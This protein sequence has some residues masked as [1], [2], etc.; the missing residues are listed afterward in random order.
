[1]DMHQRAGR[2]EPLAEL[3]RERACLRLVTLDQIAPR[4]QG[5]Y[6]YAARLGAGFLEMLAMDDNGTARLLTDD[7]VAGVGA[8]DL[9]RIGRRN[10]RRLI[11]GAGER[12]R[13]D[14]TELHVLRGASDY[15]ASTL[16]LL[17]ELLVLAG[18]MASPSDGVLL[19][20][21]NRYELAFTPVG[22]NVVQDLLAVAQYARHLSDD[23]E[24][25]V[26]PHALW[27]HR[28]RLAEVTG[29][30]PDGAVTFVGPA[31]FVRV[32]ERINGWK[33]AG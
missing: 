15:V 10:L 19:A 5:R 12:V 18:R 7:E 2:Q 25:A 22:P 24:A 26:S 23:D 11:P 14:G 20:V 3:P 21:P 29:F 8:A 1:M 17:P 30:D 16:L 6:G 31:E 9:R 32:V 27:W 33:R 4:E 28:G 13:L